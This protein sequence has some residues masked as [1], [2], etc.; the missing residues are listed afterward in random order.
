MTPAKTTNAAKVFASDVAADVGVR[1]G[2]PR[3]VGA[4]A[5]DGARFVAPSRA[6]LAALFVV[7][8]GSATKRV[9]FDAHFVGGPS[10]ASPAARSAPARQATQRPQPSA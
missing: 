1:R 7:D 10:L 4:S 9:T 2:S 3:L 6:A 5:R 8:G